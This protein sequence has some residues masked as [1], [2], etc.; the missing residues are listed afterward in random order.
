MQFSLPLSVCHMLQYVYIMLVAL[1]NHSSISIS[2]LHWG[3]KLHI[4]HYI[5]YDKCKAEK[6]CFP[7]PAVYTPA[8]TGQYAV[9]L[10][11]CKVRVLPHD[12]V[13]HLRL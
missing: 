9:G 6:N 11:L 7:G 2:V 12:H 4:T 10:H 13:V 1:W 8:N 3:A 5:W